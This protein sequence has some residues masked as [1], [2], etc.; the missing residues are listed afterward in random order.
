MRCED[1]LINEREECRGCMKNRDKGNRKE[2][3]S[4]KPPL[5]TEGAPE[6]APALPTQPPVLGK[7]KSP[8]ASRFQHSPQHI[9]GMVWEKTRIAARLHF[10][11]RTAVLRPS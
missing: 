10:C 2:R 4:Y 5:G 3:C 1:Y 8:Q 11:R 6:K 9:A 7:R